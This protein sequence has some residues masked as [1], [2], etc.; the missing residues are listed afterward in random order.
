[1]GQDE[2]VEMV[3]AMYFLRSYTLFIKILIYLYLTLC[4]HR[5][6]IYLLCTIVMYLIFDLFLSMYVFPLKGIAVQSYTTVLHRALEQ[7]K[8]PLP[9]SAETTRTARVAV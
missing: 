5:Y 3:I 1:M 9:Q 8:S 2:K 4:A 7:I 6:Y